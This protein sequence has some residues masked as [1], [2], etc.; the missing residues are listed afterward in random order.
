MLRISAGGH[1]VPHA[2]GLLAFDGGVS[3]LNGLDLL[4]I[5]PMWTHGEQCADE[6]PLMVAALASLPEHVHLPP[7]RTGCWLMMG[8]LQSFRWLR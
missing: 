3:L 4:L 8:S 7:P 6:R 5:P 2:D 1:A